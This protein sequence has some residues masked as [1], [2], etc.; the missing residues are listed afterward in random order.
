MTETE[1][2][3]APPRPAAPRPRCHRRARAAVRRNV[4]PRDDRAV[5]R[6]LARPAAAHRQGHDVPAACSPRSSPGSVSVPSAGRRIAAFDGAGG[7]VPLRAQRRPVADG[8]RLAPSPRRRRG[9][10][11][12]RRFGA[13]LGDQSRRG[14]RHGR[15]RHRHH[16]PSSPSRGPTRSSAPPTSSS[17]WAAATRARCIPANA[18][19]TGNSTTPPGM[20]LDAVRTDPRRD[21]PTCR[22]APGVTQH[23][24]V[25]TDR[26]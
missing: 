7:A 26:S 9:G 8:C 17:P 24:A 19:R 20:D 13:D 22:R 12:V 4:R 5:R 15:G 11:V 25:L 3:R 2:R 23:R 14:R 16:R 18:T 21:P 6:R 10:R 1:P